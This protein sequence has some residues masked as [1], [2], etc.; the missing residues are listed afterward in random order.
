MT[1]IDFGQRSRSQWPW[2]KEIGFSWLSWKPF[3]TNV[4]YFTCWLVMSSMW[5]LLTLASLGQKWQWP[6]MS[7]WFQLIFLKTFHHL[8]FIFHQM[9]S[10]WSL[11]IIG[12]VDQ[13]SSSH[14]HRMSKWSLLI[15]WKL[16]INPKNVSQESGRGAYVSFDIS[17]SILT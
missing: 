3:I 10:R 4:S 1:P 14:R 5:T 8:V 13:R 12:S 17:C 6:W 7:K 2:M 9:T 16:I 15:S 11:L